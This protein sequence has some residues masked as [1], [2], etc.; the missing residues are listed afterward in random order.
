MSPLGRSLGRPLARP[1]AI[2][3]LALTQLRHR[4]F[5]SMLVVSA[6]AVAVLAVTLLAGLGLGV[7]ATGEAGFEEADQDVWLSGGPLEVTRD[8]GVENPIVDAHQLADDVQTHDG[9]RSAAPI[10]FHGVYAGTDPADLELVTGVGAPGTH[11]SLAFEAGEGFT[12]P[13][14]HYADGDYDGPMSYEV[15]VD[16][17]T[18]DR[19]DLA[20]GDRLYVGTSRTSAPEHEFT[21]V[22]IATTYG[23]LLG[24]PTISMPLGELQRLAGTTGG[25]RAAYVIAAADDGVAV[26]ELAADLQREYPEY[27]VR[28]SD[29]Q[30]L[31]MLESQ[32][33]VL[34]SG[35][36]LVGLAVV[37]GV[38][39]TG[40][41]LVVLVTH[42]RRQLAA[43]RALGLS[44]GLIAALVGSQGLVLGVGGGLLGVLATVPFAWGLNRVAASLTGFEELVRPTAE[45]YLVGFAIALAIGTIAALVA[46]WRASRYARVDRLGR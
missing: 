33:L 32:V 4:Q 1:L 24:T 7:L 11:E 45:V 9:V 35:A 42:Q 22:G 37:T 13:T 5:R 27:D 8:G 15:I 17:A 26:D 25:D 44:R 21:V 19:F 23:D 34:A 2:A 29:E 40:S 38:L 14:A 16:P 3:G 41:V 39:L 28:T 43:L 10:A 30:F 6:I 46:G 36:A 20:V 31:A 12:D 18:A